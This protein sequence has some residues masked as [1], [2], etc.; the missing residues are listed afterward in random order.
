[1]SVQP[2]DAY[3]SRAGPYKQIMYTDKRTGCEV[4]EICAPDTGELIARKERKRTV[5]GADLPWEL[6]YGQPV[7]EKKEVET[8]ELSA[9]KNPVFFRQDTPTDWCWRVRNIP[10]PAQNYE[11]TVDETKNQIVIRTKNKK[12]FK[13]IDAPNGEKMNQHDVNWTWQYNTLVVTH[14]KPPRVVSQ[15]RS[16]MVWRRQLPM[17]DEGD[18]D[19]GTQ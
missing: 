6:T 15:D 5:Y 11:V 18:V 2:P 14:K 19:C 1:M 13:R 16:D 12:Y 3:A 8:L 7:Q 4:V 17:K 9:N 10:Y